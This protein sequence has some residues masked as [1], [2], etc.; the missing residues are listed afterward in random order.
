MPLPITVWAV[1]TATAV[2]F[3]TVGMLWWYT[4]RPGDGVWPGHSRGRHR[5]RPLP[6]QGDAR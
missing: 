1:I 5:P 2:V 6:A 4:T 3:A